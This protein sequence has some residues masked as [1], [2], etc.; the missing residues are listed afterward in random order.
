MS[1]KEDYYNLLNIKKDASDIAIKKSY[2]KLAMKYHPDRNPNNK[3]AEEKFKQISE[4]YEVLSDSNK[5]QAYDQF[6][7]EGLEQN[8]AGSYSSEKFTDIFSD[9][10]GDVFQNNASTGQGF[11]QPGADLRYKLNLNL[12]EAV[13]GTTVKIRLSTFISCNI[14]LGNGNQKGSQPSKCKT[15][16][17]SGQIRMQQ[18]FF[19]IQQT[20]RKCNGQGLT[21]ENPCHKC[22]GKGRIKDHKTLSVKIPPGVDNED[23]I[24]LNGEGEAGICNGQT[25]NLYV[26]I[27]V[28][29]Y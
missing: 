7:H 1:Y 11:S 15:C 18:G 12:D 8:N 14:C 10:F 28:N 20:C 6:G 26:E 19:S 2:R 22:Y 16:Q 13:K 9:I 29:E 5:R 21:I 27:N 17:G 24:R 3:E 25:G 4:A 23:R